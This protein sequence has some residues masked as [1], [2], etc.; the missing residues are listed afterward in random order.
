MTRFA[1]VLEAVAQGGLT[2]EE[3][4]VVFTRLVQGGWSDVEIAGLLGALRAR[5][6][7]AE[8]IAG[9]AEALRRAAL[10]FPS[11]TYLFADTCGTG[12]D[13]AGTLNVSTAAA[14][15]AAEIGVP[16]A[17]HGNRAVSSRCGS[18]DVLEAAG[19]NIE[20]QP[21]T[22]RRC[23]DETGLCFLFAPMYHAGVRHAMPVRRAFATRTIFNLLGPLA[24]P[25]RP[26]VQLVGV[27]SPALCRPVAL[28]LG[29]L[30]ARA[31]L[32]V[33]G[34]GLDEIALHDVTQ[35]ALWRD[36]SLE[37]ITLS[38]EQAG[39]RRRTLGD[40]RGGDPRHNA[41]ALRR[42]LE[43]KGTAGYR[44]ATVLN[45][46]AVVWLAG[47]ADTFA[48]GVALACRALD[49]G[50]CAARLDRLAEASHGD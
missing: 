33:H 46:G 5:G 27:C 42:L 12:G 28:T 43:G 48:S 45:A 1:E 29:L 25:A 24:N 7:T 3:A 23:L 15:V 10:S 26:P 38:P 44:D 31:A 30:G 4:L 11:P 21:D 6:E 50:R 2:R 32:V 13:G 35:A 39:L 9:A 14:V 22:A 19:V 40:L 41:A 34:G 8:E 47:R 18:A 16:I 20:A 49:S 17:K 36:G 37:E